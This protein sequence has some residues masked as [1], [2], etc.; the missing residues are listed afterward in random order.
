MNVTAFD[1]SACLRIGGTEQLVEA[2]TETLED[3]VLVHHFYDEDG[4]EVATVSTRPDY[5]VRVEH[6]PAEAAA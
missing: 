3:G 5:P 4:N 1:P 2:V 6:A